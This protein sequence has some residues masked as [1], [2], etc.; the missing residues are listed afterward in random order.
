ME[1]FSYL[2]HREGCALYFAVLE[3]PKGWRPGS[4][5]G[6]RRWEGVEGTVCSDMVPEIGEERVYLRGSNRGADMRINQMNFDTEQDAIE[7]EAWVRRLL[8]EF[9]E[10]GGFSGKR[11]APEASGTVT[12]YTI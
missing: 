9:V 6:T 8:A 11:K 10:A 4:P 5:G 12:T 3:Q 2:L 7:K 1:K